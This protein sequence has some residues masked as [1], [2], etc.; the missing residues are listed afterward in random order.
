[1]PPYRHSLLLA[2]L[3]CSFFFGD[4][5]L[6]V[7]QPPESPTLDREYKERVVDWISRELDQTYIFLE[8]AQEMERMIRS[9]FE[10]GAYDSI[11]HL[12]DFADLLTQDLQSISRDKH[13]RIRYAPEPMPR[14][15]ATPEELK[16]RQELQLRRAQRRNFTFQKVEILPGNVGYLRL[17]GFLDAAAGGD[18]AV[19]ALSFLAHCDALIIDLRHNR[20]GNPS[21]IQLITSYFFDEPKHINSFYIR[22]SDS[23]RQFWTHAHIQGKRMAGV[24][25]YVLTSSETFSAAEEFTY[26]LKSMDRATIVG[27]TTGGGAHPVEYRQSDELRIGM[28]VPFGR[29]VNPITG[30]NWEG[31]GVA[32]NV[33][34]DAGGALDEAYRLALE[35]LATKAEGEEKEEL[36]LTLEYRNAL[37]RSQPLSDQQQAYVGQYGPRAV[38][39]ENGILYYRR[40][41]G[42]QAR[43]YPISK[44]RFALEDNEFFRL[45]FER[46]DSGRIVAVQGHYLDGRRDR[47]EKNQEP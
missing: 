26:N 46:D 40:D 39:I 28:S 41:D 35:S 36:R 10:S 3:F 23:T 34:T 16:R 29:A 14:D 30:T 20:G 15:D 6:S 27:E 45:Q 17:D 44:D 38:F 18:T 11:S 5:G 13:L 12:Q 47:N 1:M 33:E 21:M 19:A 31:T 25:L 37:A 9:R 2:G 43:M 4:S 42:H 22:K 7:T 8:K 32:P 24:E